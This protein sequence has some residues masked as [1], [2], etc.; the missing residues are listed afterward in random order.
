M[1][2]ALHENLVRQATKLVKSG[3]MEKS[4][5]N[6]YTFGTLNKLKKR[7]GID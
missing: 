3:T 6:A 1:P 2:K 4:K 5:K 7:Y